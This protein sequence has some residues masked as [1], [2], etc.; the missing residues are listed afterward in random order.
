MRGDTR[1]IP[2]QL[3]MDNANPTA[4]IQQVGVF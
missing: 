1:D 2:E 4:D 3:M